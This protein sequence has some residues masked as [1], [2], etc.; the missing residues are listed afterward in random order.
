MPWRSKIEFSPIRRVCGG[1]GG[2]VQGCSLDRYTTQGVCGANVGGGGD[3]SIS[4]VM[5]AKGSRRREMARQQSEYCT[6][7]LRI[8]HG[9]F[10]LF[11]CVYHVERGLHGESPL[12]VIFAVAFRSRPEGFEAIGPSR[13]LLLRWRASSARPCLL[14][15]NCK[16]FKYTVTALMNYF[17]LRSICCFCS[18]E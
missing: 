11:V 14:C 3:E 7:Q 15:S 8:D 12:L 17:V 10:I 4:P 16:L 6:A 2:V 13:L 5:K 9:H 1:E 18:G